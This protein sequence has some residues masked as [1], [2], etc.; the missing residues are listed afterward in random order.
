MTATDDVFE[1]LVM[2]SGL[3]AAP[4]IDPTMPLDPAIPVPIKGT[5]HSY[6]KI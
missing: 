1:L 5:D 3:I 4:L 2:V 6:V